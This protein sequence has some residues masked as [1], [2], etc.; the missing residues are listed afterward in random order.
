MK[1]FRRFGLPSLSALLLVALVA[2]GWGSINIIDAL[3]MALLLLVVP[4]ALTTAVTPHVTDRLLPVSTALAAVAVIV[5]AETERRNWIAI[6][7]AGVWLLCTVAAALAASLAWLGSD[8]PRFALRFLLDPAVRVFAVVGAAWLVFACA[9]GPWLGFGEPIV[10]L[11]AV[12]FHVVGIGLVALARQRLALA[13]TGSSEY[14]I[15]ELAGWASLIGIPAVAIGHNTVGAVEFIGALIMTAAAWGVAAAMSLAAT[16][17]D[18]WHKNLLVL[19][20]LAPI[21]PMLLA[22]HY[23][24]SRTNLISPLS[25]RTI[26]SIH[27]SMNLFGFLGLGLLLAHHERRQAEAGQ[28]KV[29]QAKAWPSESRPDKL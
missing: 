16:R 19:S 10:E 5:R 7:L 8:N 18:G 12:H 11:T 13:P 9:R 17:F 2:I 21:V 4:L 14:R 22:L 6:V 25:Y 29:G 24:L 28:A 26:A 20:A 1:S 3:L 27:G 15:A 23:G